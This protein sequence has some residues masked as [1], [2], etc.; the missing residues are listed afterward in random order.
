ME[1]FGHKR[2]DVFLHQFGN[3]VYSIYVLHEIKR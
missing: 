3:I 2:K 1:M